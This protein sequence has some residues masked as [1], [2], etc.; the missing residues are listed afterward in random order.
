MQDVI[1]LNVHVYILY[2]LITNIKS[3]SFTITPPHRH[4]RES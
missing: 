4:I 3:S 1:F 2:F